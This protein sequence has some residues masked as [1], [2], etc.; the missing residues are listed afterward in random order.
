MRPRTLFAT[1]YH[2]LTQLEEHFKNIKN[3]KMNVKDTK[4]GIV[5]LR[6]VMRGASD[7]SYGIH[8]AGLAGIPE[9][10]IERADEILKVLESENTEATRIIEAK[11]QKRKREEQ[12]GPTLFDI[13]EKKE[14]PIVD[15]IKNLDPN[16]L[17]PLEA[18][19][20]INEW[21]RKVKE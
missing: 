9:K 6:K 12:S 17:T 18:L 16:G 8:V 21:K 14:H 3:Y 1:H 5:F 20:K 10:V 15:E 2:E 19:Q 11:T 4:E 13:A 7:R